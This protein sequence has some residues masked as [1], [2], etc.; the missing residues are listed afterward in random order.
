M[1]VANIDLSMDF[2]V[3][4]DQKVSMPEKNDVT[5][6]Q[7]NSTVDTMIQVAVKDWE[8]PKAFC[9]FR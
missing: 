1:S 5:A 2:A 8:I 3:L 6:N 7:T 4:M 9:V